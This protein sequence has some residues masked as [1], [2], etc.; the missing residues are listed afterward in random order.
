MA[1]GVEPGARVGTH[2]IGDYTDLAVG[3]DNVFHALWT[4]T[5]NV[6]NVVWWYGFEFAPTA[7]HQQGVVTAS[8]NY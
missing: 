8:G 5:N 2:C 3:S 6:Q 7:V 4:D 1:A